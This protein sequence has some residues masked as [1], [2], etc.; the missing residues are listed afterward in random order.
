MLSPAHTNLAFTLTRHYFGQ[1]TA[2]VLR[3]LFN[4]DQASIKLLRF[5]LPDLKI[6]ELKRSLLVLVKYQLVDYVKTVKNCNHQYEYSIVPDRVFAFYRM[7]SFIQNSKELQKNPIQSNFLCLLLKKA[8]LDRDKLVQEVRSTNNIK[9]TSDELNILIDDL[10]AESYLACSNQNLCINIER[11]SRSHRDSLI[12]KTVSSYYHNENKIKSLSEAILRLTRDTTSYEASLT[13]PASLQDI[14]N[15]LVPTSFPDISTLIKYLD[16]LT[17]ETNNRF[18]VSSGIH[19]TKGPMYALDVGNSIDLLVKEHLSSIITT[20][21]GPKCCRVFRIL[22]LKGPLLLKQVEDMIMLPAR[23]VREYSYM[24]IKEGFIRNRQVPKTPDNAPGKSL[25]IMFV[26]LQQVVSNATDLCCRSISNLLNRYDH[27]LLKHKVLLDR[28][29]A[30]QELLA[31]N[32][33]PSVSKDDWNQ[34][35]N[36]HELSKLEWVKRTLDKILVAKSQVDESLFLLHSWSTLQPTMRV[37][38]LS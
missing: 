27:E 37:E 11:F 6:N 32:T 28:S 1:T 20:R 29:V 23:D 2:I 26:D 14:E 8:V 21:F 30:V 10:V 38:G 25:F 5:F 34:Y 3:A 9:L 17:T 24:L 22:L 7:P 31:S 35:F 16:K 4:C 15:A 33:D 36:S 19:P 18:I 12:A 13:S